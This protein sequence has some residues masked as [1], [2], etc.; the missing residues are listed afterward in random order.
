M[1][2][3]LLD[4]LHDLFTSNGSKIDSIEQCIYI[5][6]PSFDPTYLLGILKMH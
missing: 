3:I 4:G 2:T 1:K 5:Y 6:E